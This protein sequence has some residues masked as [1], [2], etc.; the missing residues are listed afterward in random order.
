MKQHPLR[1]FA[2]L[3]GAMMAVMPAFVC[4]ADETDDDDTIE[5]DD[6][7]MYTTN[8]SYF[9]FGYL[10]DSIVITECSTDMTGDLVIPDTLDGLPVTAI[11]EGAFYEVVG[12]TSVQM[13]E[14][15][16]SIGPGAFYCCTGLQNVNLPDGLTEIGE[17]AFYQCEA[18]KEIHIPDGIT[19]IPDSC[20]ALCYSLTELTFP[21]NLEVIET[22][23]FY[24]SATEMDTLV[25]P[26]TVTEIGELAFYYWDRIT[27]VTIP[28]SVRKM[29]DYVFDGCDSLT[30]IIVAE[31]NPA[32]CDM[33]G[34]LFD[35]E[36][37]ILIKYPADKAGES[38][39]VPD[40]VTTLAGWAFVAASKLK[41]IDLN[42]VTSFGNETF[43]YCTSLES[44][45]LPETLTTIPDAAFT[46]CESL[47]S[48][49][50][51]AACTS[52]GSYC[53]VGCSSMKEVTIPSTVAQIGDYAFGFDLDAETQNIVPLDDFKMNVM[54][55]TVGMEYAK[56]FDVKY[57]SNS[58]VGIII[59]VVVAVIVIAAVVMG[60][61][62]YRRN[63]V[64]IAAGPNQGK[65]VARQK[66]NKPKN[67]GK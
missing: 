8:D 45:A 20:F 26:D 60:I 56:E 67:G 62:I 39:Q 38:Y 19:T 33:D 43:Y 18:L 35:L 5:Y 10:E 6:M 11:G 21:K 57:R 65:P 49:T 4:F 53:F 12:L 2:A 37:T 31:G 30:E 27:T 22:Q 66:P 34:V 51:P 3:L 16:T 48:I 28:A 44:I 14:T 23:A 36:K 58:K 55:G 47:A 52:I 32:Y 9:T 17:S 1:G 7:G 42:D 40:G 54:V 64:R 50:I 15:V 61:V 59:A 24:G 13:P 29:G 46:Y 41:Q 63:R 25:I